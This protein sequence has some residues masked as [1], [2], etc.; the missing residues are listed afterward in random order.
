MN[1]DEKLQQDIENIVSATEDMS[2]HIQE[3]IKDIAS[4]DKNGKIN[5]DNVTNNNKAE[6]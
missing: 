4:I 3:K 5:K 6:N 2:K 1:L